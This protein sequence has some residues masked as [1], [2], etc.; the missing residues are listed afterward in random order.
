MRRLAVKNSAR[1]QA[2]AATASGASGP[3]PSPSISQAER[4][5]DRLADPADREQQDRGGD[6][7]EDVVEAGEQP[8]LL[9]VDRWQR[10]AGVRRRCEARSRLGAE[11]ARGDGLVEIVLAIHGH[12]L[13][14]DRNA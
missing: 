3:G 10:A 6:R 13:P 9:L 2:V 7:D 4:L 1:P 8:E 14:E 11:R 5:A 12:S